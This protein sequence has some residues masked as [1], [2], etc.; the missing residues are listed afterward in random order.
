M[1]TLLDFVARLILLG[2]VALMFYWLRSILSAAE[3]RAGCIACGSQLNSVDLVTCSK[4]LGV[5]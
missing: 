4:C 3:L 5:N 1:W 2:G